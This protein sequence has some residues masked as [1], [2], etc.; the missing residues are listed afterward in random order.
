MKSLLKNNKAFLLPLVLFVLLSMPL[1]ILLSKGTIHLY[2]NAHYTI[3]LD[4]LFKYIT[5]LGDGWMPVLLALPFL[6]YSVQ[7]SVLVLS[8]GLL[9]GIL[10]QIFKKLVFPEIVRPVKFFEGMHDLHLV[11]GVNIHYA[12]S[13]PSGHSAT[14]FALCF[15]LAIFTKK[16]L[17]KI[18]LFILATIV[19]FS[20]VYLSQ[21]F[22]N[23]IVFGAVIGC[24]A[25]ICMYLL[26]ERVKKPWFSKALIRLRIPKNE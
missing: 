21:H 16:S 18:L 15:C 22:L 11:E 12:F 19:A 14:I 25:T 4:Y 13:F 9:A 24:T 8:S 6:F 2:I 3:T 10:A 1:F 7:K 5:F 23:D 26:L 20:R 17:L